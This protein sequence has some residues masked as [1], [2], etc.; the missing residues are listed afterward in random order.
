MN[1][2]EHGLF[3]YW[4]VFIVGEILIIPRALG[5]RVSC[6]PCFAL[7]GRP[8][9]SERSWVFIVSRY[10]WRHEQPPMTFLLP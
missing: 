7:E 5:A 10:R 9:R 3:H 6:L 2:D 4:A 1:T 8:A